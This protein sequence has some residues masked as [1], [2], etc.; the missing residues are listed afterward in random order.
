MP[1]DWWTAMCQSV[2]HKLP[3][4]SALHLVEQRTAVLE[5]DDLLLTQTL[6]SLIRKYCRSECADRR[7][8]VFA[9]LSLA[10]DCVLGQTFQADYSL[11]RLELL[12]KLLRFCRPDEP[13][14]FV[15]I[16][17]RMLQKAEGDDAWKKA[18]IEWDRCS[19]SNLSDAHHQYRRP[20]GHTGRVITVAQFRAVST[21]NRS[22]GRCLSACATLELG[23][24]EAAAER[25][26]SFAT[27]LSRP[28]AFPPN[29][30]E[31]DDVVFDIDEFNMAILLNEAQV[32]ILSTSGPKAVAMTVAK[33]C[34]VLGLREAGR[35]CACKFS[36]IRYPNF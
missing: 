25:R 9:L 24:M 33:P 10:C 34:V 4:S 11:P 26:P 32:A 13:I 2:H 16:V 1:W 29:S 35:D 27:T 31:Y 21:D 15:S 30:W 28:T 20:A 5:N 8:R 14:G 12:V 18:A 7:D 6:E 23:C 3:Q 19:I 17:F 22:W 36:D